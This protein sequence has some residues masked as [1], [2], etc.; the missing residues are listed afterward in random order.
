MFSMMH[1]EFFSL[2]MFSI[3]FDIL[4]VA[5]VFKA[6]T[7]LAS[8]QIHWQVMFMIKSTS[9]PEFFRSNARFFFSQIYK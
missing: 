6:H 4:N 3:I 7:A 5:S 2:S 1:Y 9:L 8:K